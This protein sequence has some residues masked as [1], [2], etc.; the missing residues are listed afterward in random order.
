[1]YGLLPITKKQQLRL[2][3]ST[4]STSEPTDTVT[5]EVFISCKDIPVDPCFH[6]T[7]YSGVKMMYIEKTALRLVTPWYSD[8]YNLSAYMTLSLD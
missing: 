4:G 2:M 5:V 1:M 6:D 8:F 3:S 7:G